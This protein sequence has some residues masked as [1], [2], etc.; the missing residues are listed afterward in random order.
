MADITDRQKALLKM[1]IEGY[2][3]SAEPVSSS[4][5]T[6]KHKL[7]VSAATVRNE[8]ASLIRAGFLDQPHV[9]A[10]RVP[11]DLGYRFYIQNLMDEDSLPVLKE[12]AIKQN[13]WNN[14]YEFDKLLRSASLALADA[15][16]MLAVISTSDGRVFSSGMVN[17]LD[18]SE[19]FDIEVARAVLNLVDN[20]SQ[21]NDVVMSRNTSNTCVILGEEFDSE[22]L[23]SVS[24]VVKSFVCGNK[25]GHVIIVGPSRMDY[26]HL[27]P[28]VRYVS[29]VLEELGSEW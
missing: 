3:E 29:S 1:I 17:L 12:V 20:F 13:V 21:L 9:S 22:T 2:I 19:F 8:M 5:L 6:K 4:H 10:G 16:H 18:H 28:A 24:A 26:R 11:T 23:Y 14:R 15:T 7:N 25:K 27:I